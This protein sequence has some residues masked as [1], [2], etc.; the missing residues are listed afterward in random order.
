MDRKEL[1][2]NVRKAYRLAYEVQD[3]IIEI[4]E[5]IRARI[6]CTACAGLQLFSDPIEKWKSA[7]DLEA[8]QKFGKDSWGKKGS[9]KYFPTYMYMYYFQCKPTETQNCCFSIVQIMDDGFAGL[10]FKNSAPSTE[11]FKSPMDSESYLLFA[12]SIWKGHDFIWF[13]RNEKKTNLP[14]EEAEIFRIS[15]T[16]KGNGYEPYIAS[17]DASTFVV[18]R[19]SLEAIGS[20]EEAD[21]VLHDFAKLVL[22]ETGYQLLVEEPKE[23]ESSQPVLSMQSGE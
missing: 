5:Y 12:F 15:E 20:K 10:P 18:A 2:Q 6:R 8:D 9:W 3:S 7:I 16:I 1:Y 11:D 14:D 21:L 19:I 23:W 4:A 13:Y 22:D 17:N